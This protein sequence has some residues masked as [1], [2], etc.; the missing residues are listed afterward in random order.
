MDTTNRPFH[1]GAVAARRLPAIVV[2][3]ALTI[4]SGAAW[5]QAGFPADDDDDDNVVMRQLPGAVRGFESQETARIVHGQPAAKADWRSLVFIQSR[6]AS[7][8]MSSCG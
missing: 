1:I 4:M 6:L 5:A 8:R 7:G 3:A 2:A